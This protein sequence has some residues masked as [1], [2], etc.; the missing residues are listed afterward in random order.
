MLTKDPNKVGY[1]GLEC[2]DDQEETKP[3]G[4][5]IYIDVEQYVEAG[6]EVRL[7]DEYKVED[8]E[9]VYY[10]CGNAI[11]SLVDGKTVN[12]G[13]IPD[14][15]ADNDMRFRVYDDEKDDAYYDSWN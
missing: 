15:H 8:V 9:F 7:P 5:L 1:S 3:L 10:D 12:A 6:M 14:L 13:K 11:V 4:D 2:P